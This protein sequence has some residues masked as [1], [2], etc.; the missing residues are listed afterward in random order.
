MT[1][2]EAIREMDCTFPHARAMEEGWGSKDF[3]EWESRKLQTLCP[4]IDIP[5]GLSTPRTFDAWLQEQR[6][7]L[8][9]PYE[10]NP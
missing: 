1:L 3:A 2:S 6:D 8:G 4:G 10:Y 9:V 5:C 7:A